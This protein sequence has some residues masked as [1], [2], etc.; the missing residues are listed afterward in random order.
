MIETKPV[1]FLHVL[2]A[3]NTRLEKTTRSQDE[4]SF[5]RDTFYEALIFDL[6]KLTPGENS[7]EVQELLRDYLEF[8]SNPENSL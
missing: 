1:R 6:L 8:H 7:R 3:V 5:I 2:K 4:K